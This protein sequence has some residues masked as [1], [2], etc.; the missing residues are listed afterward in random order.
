[1]SKI[2]N[3]DDPFRLH[4]DSS[5]SCNRPKVI[6]SSAVNCRGLQAD[7]SVMFC[8]WNLKKPTSVVLVRM[9]LSRVRD[10]IIG[11]GRWD[12]MP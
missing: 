8:V 12:L 11:N 10:G 5:A 7:T 2:V 3:T 4:H 6:A 9:G 1:M